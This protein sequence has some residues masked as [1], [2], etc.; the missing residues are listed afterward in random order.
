MAK[1]V[2]HKVVQDRPLRIPD[3]AGPPRGAG[4]TRCLASSSFRTVISNNLDALRVF[5]NPNI[6]V[7][8][9]GIISEAEATDLFK[10]YFPSFYFHNPSEIIYRF[11]HGCST[12]LPVFDSAVDTFASLHERS[13]FA[14]DSICMVAARVRDGGGKTSCPCRGTNVA[15]PIFISSGKP[16]DVYTKCLQEVQ[17]ISCATL[18][19]PV[20]RVE[21]VQAMSA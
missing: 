2:T 7:V 9:K 8:S 4:I 18:F 20:L 19:A 16:S 14:V 11:F 12:F 5:A 21:A 13:P 6:L 15:K 17:T 3:H 1:Q 10:M